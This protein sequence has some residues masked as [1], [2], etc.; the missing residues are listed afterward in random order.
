MPYLATTGTDSCWQTWRVQLADYKGEWNGITLRYRDY[1]IDRLDVMAQKAENTLLKIINEWL[2]NAQLFPNV[3]SSKY[4]VK[5]F[6]YLGPYPVPIRKQF[7]DICIRLQ[8]HYRGRY[9]TGKPDTDHL[10]HRWLDSG[11]LLCDPILFLKNDIRIRS[12][13]CFG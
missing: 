11:F 4:R 7:L 12:E 10:W 8:T 3:W 13:S 1:T 9:P 6:R 5:R 2:C